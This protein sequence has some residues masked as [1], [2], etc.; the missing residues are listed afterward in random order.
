M[1]SQF[2]PIPPIKPT[3]VVAIPSEPGLWDRIST[4][5]SENKAAVYT[6]AGVSVLV[7]GAGIYY[8]NSGPSSKGDSSR[9]SKKERRKRKEAEKK[10]SAEKDA[11]PAQTGSST[12]QAASVSTNDEDLLDISEADIEALSPEERKARAIKLKEAGNKSYGARDYPR[13]IDLYTKAILCKPDPVYYSNRAACYSAQKEWEKVVE[14]TT[15]AI[16]LDPDYV[17]ALNRRAAAYENMDKY[18]ESLLDYTASCIIDGFRNDSSAQAVERLLKKFAESKAREIM[19]SKEPKL[20]SPTFIGNY[21]QSF[22]AKPRPAGLEDTVDLPED[23]GKGQLQRGL[24]ELEKKTGDRYEAAAEAFDK[25]L[26]LG[27]LGEYEALA[28]NMRGTFKCLRGKHEEA[29]QDLTKCVELD[30]SMTQG[31]IKRASMYLELGKTQEAQADFETASTQ[32]P[33]DPDIYYHRAQ[34]HFIQGEFPE[35]AKDYQKSIDLDRDFIFS[36]IQLGVT[37]YKMGSIAS[38][39]ATFRRCVKNF[40]KVPEVY[41][42]FGEL[43]MD[44][45]RFPDAVEKFDTAIELEKSARPTDMNV[46]PLINKALALFQWKQDFSEAEK[47]CEKALIIDPECDIAVATMAQLQLQQGKVTE[48]LKQFERAAEL[49]RTEGELVNALS[50]AEATRTQITVQE[51][52]PKL[53]ARLQG[54]GPAGAMGR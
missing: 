18:S 23:S 3:P 19:G 16:N 33:E 34:L 32:N 4:W 30:P 5:A 12:P 27:D 42:Y 2:P 53:A 14:D 38:S 17:K 44:Q 45:N 49:A 52:Y 48:A 22:R 40:E 36:H 24:A 35:A 10:A 13:A 9:P 37:Q 41:N 11:Q 47:L 46:L 50:Y 51:K 1:S 25:A 54:M 20:P 43:L 8:I 28:Y 7:T 26:Q 31:Y 29:L 15:A 39:M 21:L 6:I